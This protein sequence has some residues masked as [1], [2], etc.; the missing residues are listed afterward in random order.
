LFQGSLISNTIENVLAEG[1]L[2]AFRSTLKG[3]QTGSL[4]VFLQH[5]SGWLGDFNLFRISE[6]KIVEWWYEINL[7][8]DEATRRDFWRV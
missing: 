7:L 4:W 5:A 2:V 8:G 3:I 6:G 1:D